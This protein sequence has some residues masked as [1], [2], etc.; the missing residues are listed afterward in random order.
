[1]F[2]DA[3]ATVPVPDGPIASGTN[4]WLQST[5]PP[6]AVL[7]AT[8]QATVPAGNVYLY[9]GN[10]G[11]NSAQK[12]ILAISATLKTTVRAVAVFQPPGSLVVTKTIAGPAAAQH[13]PILIV[14]T[15]NG[16][17]VPPPLVIPAGAP[18]ALSQTYS[19]IAAGSVCTVLETQDRHTPDVTARLTGS[20]TVVTI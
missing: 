15:C 20:G 8:A 18:G 16:T 3:A 7:A 5:G 11:V 1:M 10:S 6:K 12:L 9:D 19:P 17:V 13:G 2:A 4:I 14:V